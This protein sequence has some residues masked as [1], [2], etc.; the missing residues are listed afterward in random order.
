MKRAAL[1]LLVATAA[2]A[3]P[4]ETAE[5]VRRVD[6]GNKLYEAGRYED[7]LRLYLAAYDLAPNPDTL[8]NIGLAHE[9]L[10]AFEQCVIAFLRYIA[11]STDALTNERAT[12][13]ATRCLE[14]TT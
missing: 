3:G 9:K 5:A 11:E 8:F 6:Q 2:S 10:L 1:L 12:E 14:R 4:R 7:A 13:R